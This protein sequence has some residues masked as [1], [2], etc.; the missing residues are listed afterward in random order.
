MSDDIIGDIAV[1]FFCLV[2][3]LILGIQGHDAYLNIK[4]RYAKKHD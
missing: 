1:G 3:I 2:L 4:Q